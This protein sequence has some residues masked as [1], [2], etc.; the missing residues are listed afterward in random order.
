MNEALQDEISALNS[1]YGDS[2]LLPSPTDPPPP[3]STSSPYPLDP[4]SPHPP[5]S[6]SNSPFLPRRPPSTLSTHSSNPALPKGTAARDL[7]LF[8]D[9]ITQVHTPGQVCLFDAIESFN[10]LLTLATSPVPSPSPP[11]STPQSQPETSLPPTSLDLKR[12]LHR[13]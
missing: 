5:P 11:L 12:P 9:A 7:S 4:S 6:S 10:D 3:Q 1:I 13:A 2:T 8:R